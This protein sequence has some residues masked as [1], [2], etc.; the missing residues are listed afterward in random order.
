MLE[1]KITAEE[2]ETYLQE[3]VGRN[4]AEFYYITDTTVVFESGERYLD[5]EITTSKGGKKPIYRYE[6]ELWIGGNWQYKKD[7]QVMETTEVKFNEDGP[8]YRSRIGDFI[9]TIH[10][11]K[12]TAIKVSEDGKETTIILDSGGQFVVTPRGDSYISYT[13]RTFDNDGRIVETRHVRPNENTGELVH[14][15]AP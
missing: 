1:K 9:E 4:L 13:N 11:S 6:F 2:F 14:I 5:H 12:I 7:G 3:F 8:K 10:P 15:Q